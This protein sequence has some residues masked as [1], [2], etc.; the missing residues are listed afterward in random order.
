MTA[1][2]IKFIQTKRSYTPDPV[3]ELLEGEVFVYGDN[4][5]HYHGAGAAKAALK[6]GAKHYVGGQIV[7][8]TYGIPTKEDNIKDIMS[9]DDIKA[10]IRRFQALAAEHYDKVFLV[11]KIGCGY[12]NPYRK[13]K[14]GE[15]RRIEEI[16]TLFRGSPPNCVFPKEFKNYL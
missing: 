6:W 14:G 2:P 8:Q 12:A 15:E 10:E 1:M 7:G 9:I 13:E 16:A 3:K 5:K 4:L 11:T